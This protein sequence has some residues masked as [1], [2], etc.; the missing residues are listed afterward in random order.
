M[1]LGKRPNCFRVYDKLAE[2][3]R[4]WRLEK[5]R[6]ERMAR[7]VVI[8]KAMEG[9]PKLRHTPDVFMSQQAALYHAQKRRR[10]LLCSGRYYFP[11]PS[12][13]SWFRDQCTGPMSVLVLHTV[14]DIPSV[15]TRVER[16]MGA[17]RVP[18]ELNSFQ[19][20]FTSGVEFNPF[21]RLQFSPFDADTTVDP[22]DY[23]LIDLAAGMQ[24]KQWLHEGMTY[25]HL[26]AKLDEQRH[27]KQLVEKFAPFV[28]AANPPQAVTISSAE[29]YERYRDSVSRQMAA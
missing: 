25:Q 17:G 23:S 11:F 22:D 2:R 5:G 10:E 24:I 14:E 28:A 7:Q 18:E 19:K 3:R 16:Q 1:Y 12:F 8:D 6:H 15:F 29:L 26:Y 20:L 13:E 9:D 4:A 21:D 27:G